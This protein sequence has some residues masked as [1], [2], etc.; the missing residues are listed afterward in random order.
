MCLNMPKK[1]IIPG[2]RGEEKQ[3]FKNQE[4]RNKK[5]NACYVPFVLLPDSCYLDSKTSI[6]GNRTAYSAL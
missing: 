2:S 3:D 6:F 1:P 4:S 5:Q